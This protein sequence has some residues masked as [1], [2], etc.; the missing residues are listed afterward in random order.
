VVIRFGVILLCAMLALQGCSSGAKTQQSLKLYVFDCGILSFDSI[1]AF[2]VAADETDVRDLSVPC[3]VVE[4]EKGRLLWEGGLASTLAGA[5]S[6]EEEGMRMRLD[7]TL[8]DQLADL[9]LDMGAFD[10]MAFSHLHHDH[11]GVANE[12]E[13]ATL[14]I[15]KAEHDAAFADQVTVP[16]YDPALYQGIRNAKSV[17][18]EGDH[19]VFGDGRVRILS[20]PGHTPGH[21]V[22]FVDLAATGPVVLAGDLYHFRVSRESRRVP[23]F[24]VDGP[25]TFESMDRIEAF[26]AESGAELW[27]G[28]ELALFG[29]LNKAPLYYD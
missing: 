12:V 29:R 21:Q 17:I 3:F 14:I 11:V 4:H 7:R 22:L 5:G 2:G 16:G 15:Q 20:A 8:S 26:V 23:T 10:Y 27:I 24:N 18:V 28:H 13:G 1:E 25:M 9:G 19:D 6:W